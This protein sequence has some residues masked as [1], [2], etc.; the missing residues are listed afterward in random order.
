MMA[1]L[2]DDLRFARRAFTK[3]PGF[4]AVVLSTL[5]LGIGAV[6]AIFSVADG[7]LVKPLPYR[8][9][10]R[11]IRIGHVRPDTAVPGASFSPQDVEDLA[12]AH[13]GLERVAS[14]SY[15]PS[16]SGADLTGSGE[17]ERVPAAEV[18]GAF[19]ETLGMPAL[20]GRFL[21]PEDDRAGRNHVAVI[22]S[23]L[24]RRRFGGERGI[25]GRAV[26][27]GG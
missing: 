15:S 7:V 3:N 17:P 24:W 25:V 11:L 9:P 4:T 16:Q 14:W 8:D 18:S 27:A 6:V 21:T 22:S 20:V 26:V 10:G 23:A 13:P 2:I 5:A 1:T 19:F 12:S